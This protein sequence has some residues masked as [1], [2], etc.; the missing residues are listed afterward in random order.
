MKILTEIK[1]RIIGV[2]A[3][4]SDDIIWILVWYEYILRN[5]ANLRLHNPEILA[6]EGSKYGQINNFN[7][8]VYLNNIQVFDPIY[9]WRN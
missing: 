5:I 3:E 8:V 1:R 9:K 7:T 6:M 2:S 4:C